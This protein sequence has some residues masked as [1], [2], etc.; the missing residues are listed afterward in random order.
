MGPDSRVRRR[1]ATK[2]DHGFHAFFRHYYNLRAFMDK[3]GASQRFKIIDD[4]LV[5]AK[6]GKQYS[7]KNVETT[8]VLNILSLGRNKFFRFRDVLF[9]RRSRRMGEFLEY[10]EAKTFAKY[11]G[12]TFEEF[13]LQR[14]DVVLLPSVLSDA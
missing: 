1:H 13:F 10:D 4:Y 11:D 8:P 7:F 5:L 6:D 14:C 9:N 12:M 2:V 3:I